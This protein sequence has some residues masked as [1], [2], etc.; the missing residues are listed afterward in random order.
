MGSAKTGPSF[1]TK[2][3]NP[4]SSAKPNW[5]RARIVKECGGEFC[6]FKVGEIVLVNPYSNEQGETTIEREKWKGSTVP[7]C[8]S[9][10]GIPLDALEFLPPDPGKGWHLLKPG[11]DRVQDGDELWL[12]VHMHWEKSRL[13]PGSLTFVH[14]FYRR[15]DEEQNNQIQGH[16]VSPG[17][18]G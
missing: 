5:R 14:S 16:E 15:R 1:M 8:N 18:P 13:I 11:R 7:P 4:L 2:T 17:M 3:Y 10:Y 12:P 6:R 9:C